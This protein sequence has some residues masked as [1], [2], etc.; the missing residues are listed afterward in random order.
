MK[1]NK[2]CRLLPIL[3]LAL[4]PGL[5]E[6]L[7]ASPPAAA[8]SAVRVEGAVSRAVGVTVTRTGQGLHIRTAWVSAK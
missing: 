4:L 7:T 1:K 5:G 2:Y 6:A 8:P 3:I